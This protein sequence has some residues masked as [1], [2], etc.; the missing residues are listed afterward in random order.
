MRFSS[1]KNKCK[2]HGCDGVRSLLVACQELQKFVKRFPDAR[3]RLDLYHADEHL[4]TTAHDLYGKDT[5]EARQ[6]VEPLLKQLHQDPWASDIFSRFSPRTKPTVQ[7][8][9]R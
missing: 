2:G 3:C 6:W 5:P 1:R 7:Q 8:I 9:A 4:W